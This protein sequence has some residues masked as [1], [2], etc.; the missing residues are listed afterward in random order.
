[1]NVGDRVVFL[2]NSEDE[3]TH[4]MQ[5]QFYPTAGTIGEVVAG[6]FDNEKTGVWVQWPKGTTSGD[7]CWHAQFFMLTLVVDEK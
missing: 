3:R 6:A 7:D 5:P 1:M 2:D 4:E